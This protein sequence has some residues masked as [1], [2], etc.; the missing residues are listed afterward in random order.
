M[1]A[2]VLRAG[3]ET[4]WPP[5]RNSTTR[6]AR[7]RQT[8]GGMINR[9]G[10]WGP[11]SNWLS[12]FGDE[13]APV[14]SD[15]AEA[16]AAAMNQSVNI[17]GTG[18]YAVWNFQTPTSTLGKFDSPWDAPFDSHSTV[19]VYEQTDSGPELVAQYDPWWRPW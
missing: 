18:A 16:A 5:V 9:F 17:D 4:S 1:E 7:D 2:H 19:H 6:S 13:T 14:S 15:Y 11:V 10:H 8:G 3:S 12:A